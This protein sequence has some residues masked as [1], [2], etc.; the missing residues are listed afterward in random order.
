MAIYSKDQLSQYFEHISLPDKWRASEPSL[1]HLTELVKHQFST[2][3]FENISLHYSE[4]HALSLD[5]EDLFLKIVVKS[6]GG[7]C[8]ENN[9]F[10]GTV[11]RSL[12]FH[13]INAGARVSEATE[14]RPGGRYGGW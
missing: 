4:N 14:G 10:F 6:R 9:T 5:P 8:M 13:I 7:Y 3:P 2:V 1:G 12:G 11:L